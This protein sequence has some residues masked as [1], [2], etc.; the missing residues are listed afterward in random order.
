MKLSKKQTW[1]VVAG[2]AVIALL[3]LYYGKNGAVGSLQNAFA[4][5]PAY[6]YAYSEEA[7]PVMM[8]YATDE[9]KVRSSVDGYYS[10]T[11][12]GMMMN[13]ESQK[14]IQTASL[15]L[16]VDDV[17]ATA[18]KVT[19][20]VE[21]I[22]GYIENASVDRYDQ[23]YY[24]YLTLRVP[25]DKF[26][27]ILEELKGM[28]NYVVSEYKNA[29]DV[30]ETYVDLQARLENYKAEEQQ[31][32]AIMDKA[33]TV[34]WILQVTNALYQVR[35]EIESLESRLK[36]YDTRVDYSSINLSLEEDESASRVSETWRPLST[37]HSAYADWV[38]F[39]QGLVDQAIY[40]AIY[41]WPL[42]LIVLVV[43]V[44]RRKAKKSR[45]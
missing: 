37:L 1:F 8:D 11:S 9:M 33:D 32:L 28:A 7:M 5:S 16:H 38:G 44:V 20:Y 21:S 31:Y 23:G 12:G 4:P 30:T 3:V 40:L 15:G 25:N 13:T 18:E 19:D 35:A 29:E 26:D 22:G 34:E 17:R 43:W 10:E 14:I 36:Y 27:T 42:A 6:D 39:L 24:G 2:I 41:I 45:K